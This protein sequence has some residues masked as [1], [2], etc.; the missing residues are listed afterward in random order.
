MNALEHLIRRFI[1]VEYIIDG[2]AECIMDAKLASLFP[3][4]SAP[5][6]RKHRNYVFLDHGPLVFRKQTVLVQIVEN[7]PRIQE[8]SKQREKL[9]ELIFI[10]I[11]A[12]ET[13]A[14]N[15]CDFLALGN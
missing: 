13:S 3:E 10:K 6:F 14:K 15:R 9:H 2:L 1:T 11:L 4:V 8:L 5:G 7:A 12:F